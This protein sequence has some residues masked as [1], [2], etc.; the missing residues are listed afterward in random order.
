MLSLL[1][2]TAPPDSHN[3]SLS[4]LTST[5]SISVRVCHSPLLEY[6]TVFNTESFPQHR[7]INLKTFQ[8]LPPGLSCEHGTYSPTFYDSSWACPDLCPPLLTHLPSSPALRPRFCHLRA[9]EQREDG[10]SGPKRQHFPK[11]SPPTPGFASVFLEGSQ[12]QG[13]L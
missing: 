9:R 12:Q 11:V 3:S 4:N 7:L 8:I 1:W 10:S 6:D 2:I 13:W 5:V